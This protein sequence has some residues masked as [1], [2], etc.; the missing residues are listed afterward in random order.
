MRRA[1]K[2]NNNIILL[3]R[4]ILHFHLNVKCN[5]R[6]EK[7]F[8]SW[9]LLQMHRRVGEL[10]GKINEQ[11]F[12]FILL[13]TYIQYNW[14]HWQTQGRAALAKPHITSKWHMQQ[15]S[16]LKLQHIHQQMK[17]KTKQNNKVKAKEKQC[18]MCFRE[19]VIRW[20]LVSL[21]RTFQRDLFV[22]PKFVDLE[23]AVQLNTAGPTKGP[24]ATQDRYTPDQFVPRLTPAEF[25][26]PL[27][28]SKT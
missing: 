23:T 27:E 20:A 14:T 25:P 15:W 19:D 22:K 17:H 8:H 28:L 16:S 12:Y 1:I 26:L 24:R 3:L 4:Q 18:I 21:Q 9:P 10:P 5:C 2:L 11:D 6:P 13:V 7:S